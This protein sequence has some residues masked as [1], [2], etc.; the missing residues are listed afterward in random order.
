MKRKT[1]NVKLMAAL[2][3][4]AAFASNSRVLNE[5]RENRN[6]KRLAALAPFGGSLHKICHSEEVI[7]NK[8]RLQA[9]TLQ[10]APHA[11]FEQVDHLD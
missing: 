9:A 10:G 11:T 7:S 1:K 8:Y 5:K 2:A 4:L 3:R 6:V